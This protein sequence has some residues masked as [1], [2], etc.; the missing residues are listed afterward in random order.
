MMYES[1]SEQFALRE[2]HVPK[3]IIELYHKKTDAPIT[4]FS[5]VKEEKA[6]F[7]HAA[8]SE[9]QTVKDYIYVNLKK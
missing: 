8:A 5:E 9:N 1:F 3:P 6:S 4:L 7:L 2:V